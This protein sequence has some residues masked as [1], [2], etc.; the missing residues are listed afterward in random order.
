MRSGSTPQSTPRATERHRIER[1]IELYLQQCY[2]TPTVARV[3]ELA[4]SLGANRTY[5]SR[6]VPRV[7][8]ETLGTALRRRQLAYAEQL[9]LQTKLPVVEIARAAA[10]GTVRT[11]FRAFSSAFGMTPAAYRRKATKCQ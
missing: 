7:L 1:A 10:F 4:A 6:V 8:G 11:F 3:S 2:R 5:L 9:L